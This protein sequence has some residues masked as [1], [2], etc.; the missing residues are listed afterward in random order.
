[1]ADLVVDYDLLTELE[2][3]LT[4][5]DQ[6]FKNLTGEVHDI[7]SDSGWGSDDIHSAMNTFQHNWRA[8]RAKLESAIDALLQMVTQTT[9]TF[10]DVDA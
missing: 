1:M 10:Q 3:S 5:V 2:R 8:H 9:G 4:F 6:E 7:D